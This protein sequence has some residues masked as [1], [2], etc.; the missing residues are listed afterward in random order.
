MHVST[1]F[2]ERQ[3]LTMRMHMCRF[4]RLTNGLV[5]EGGGPG[6]RGHFALDVLPLHAHP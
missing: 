1:S 4:A 5:K 3:N 6:Q 2:A